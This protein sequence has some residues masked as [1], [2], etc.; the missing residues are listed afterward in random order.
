MRQDITEVDEAFFKRNWAE[1]RPLLHGCTG[2][3]D[4]GKIREANDE[5]LNKTHDNK[6]AEVH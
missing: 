1:A 2:I 5:G 6:Q 4:T 3:G